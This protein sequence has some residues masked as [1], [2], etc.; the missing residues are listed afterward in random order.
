MSDKIITTTGLIRT[1]KI[2]GLKR[3]VW[4]VFI[5]DDP[6]PFPIGKIL[7]NKGEYKY[8]EGSE[9]NPWVKRQGCD[10]RD[11]GWPFTSPGA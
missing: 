1:E 4:N 5:V 8:Y 2:E 6:L 10:I 7:L 3:E 9:H 11:A